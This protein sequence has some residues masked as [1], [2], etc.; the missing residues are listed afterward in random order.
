MSLIS[1][2]SAPLKALSVPVFGESVYADDFSKFHGGEPG[3]KTEIRFSR[4]KTELFLEV[5][6]HEPMEIHAVNRANDWSIFHSGDRLEIFFGTLSSDE[7]WLTQCAIGAGGGHADNNGRSEEWNAVTEVG[8]DYWKAN[9]VFPI[10][11]F[12]LNNFY[13]YFNICRYSE[14]RNEYVTWTDLDTKFQEIEN[15]GM[16]LFDDYSR[17]YFAETGISPEKEFTRNEFE[18]AMEKLR[19][20]AHSIQHGPWLTNPTDT[21]MTVSFGSAGNCGAYLEYRLA[22]TES[23]MR[24]PF[25]CRNGIL[26]RNSRIHVLHLHGLQ[27]GAVYQ[28]RIITLHPVTAEANISGIYT[29]KTLEPER[30]NFTFTAFSDLHSNVKTIRNLLKSDSLKKSDFL[31]NIGDHLSC[32]CGQESY[33]RGFLDQEAGWCQ[34]TG[35]PLYFIRGNH[36]QIGTFAGIYQDL[37][38]HPTGKSYFTFCQGDTL[39]IALDA[40][41][42]KPDDPAGL[43]HNAEMLRE[44]QEW[45]KELSGTEMY[46]NAKWRIVLIH[47]PVYERRYDSDSAY[48]LLRLIPETDLI[49]TGHLHRYFT[50]EPE[51]G[52]CF[53]K[54]ENRTSVSPDKLSALTIAN[55]TDTLLQVEV[56][57]DYLEVKAIDQ[58]GELVDTQRVTAKK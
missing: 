34:E 30:K 19:I 7:P 29:F 23:W 48:S 18:S 36:E 33:Y 56:T 58:Y 55:D 26:I 37:L 41:N 4:S 2:A 31:V 16:L 35:K 32:A 13:M 1:Y 49:L 21:S 40:G 38:P 10:S 25:D 52:I 17:I 11:M 46:R 53:F 5:I 45:L 50:V 28:Y 44:Q 47:M 14:A 15:Y 20:P 24:F 3:A 43:F 6:C 27:P 9:A 42:D 57:E 12:K 54:R 8:R 51:T 39:F 22:G